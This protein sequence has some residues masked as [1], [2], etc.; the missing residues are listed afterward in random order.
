MCIK[1]QG[2]IPNIG[3]DIDLPVAIELH[4]APAIHIGIRDLD[5]AQRLIGVAIRGGVRCNSKERSNRRTGKERL[6]DDAQRSIW[7]SPGSCQCKGLRRA[8]IDSYS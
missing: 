6:I 8:A 3:F 7:N 2:T 4:Q 1:A 5:V